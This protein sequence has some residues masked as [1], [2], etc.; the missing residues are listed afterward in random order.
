MWHSYSYDLR[1]LIEQTRPPKSGKVALKRAFR[2]SPS[3]ACERIFRAT[4]VVEHGIV[5]LRSSPV[6]VTPMRHLRS[7]LGLS[8]LPRQGVFFPIVSRARCSSLRF[9]A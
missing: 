3:D 4:K 1:I 5:E 9:A 8:S 6:A 7:L 2:S